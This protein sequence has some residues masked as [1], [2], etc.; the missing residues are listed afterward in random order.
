MTLARRY[1]YAFFFDAPLPLPMVDEPIPGLAPLT[2]QD[3]AEVA[4]GPS[5][6]LDRVCD[7]ILGLGTD[8]QNRYFLAR[9]AV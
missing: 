3:R 9:D 4:P 5:E 7:G 1:A 2:V 6:E 8:L